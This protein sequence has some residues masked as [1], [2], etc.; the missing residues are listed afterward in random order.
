MV[1]F[2]NAFLDI[3]IR[4]KDRNLAEIYETALE[5]E[6]KFAE[7]YNMTYI[8]SGKPKKRKASKIPKYILMSYMVFCGNLS[9]SN[10]NLFNIF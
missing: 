9:A 2:Q 3:L 10:S 1:V 8:E 5:L 7:M 4:Q 6:I